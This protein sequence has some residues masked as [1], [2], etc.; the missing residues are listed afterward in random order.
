MN[1]AK[2]KTAGLQIEP[3]RDRE[4][5]ELRLIF[6]AGFFLAG[7]YYEFCAALAAIALLAWL[8]RRG[9]L[10]FRLNLASGAVAAIFCGYVLSC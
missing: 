1:V 10:R 7:L 6:A 2:K 4:L 3:L 9:R 5:P 8:W